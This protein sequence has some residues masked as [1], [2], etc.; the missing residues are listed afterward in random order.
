MPF[1]GFRFCEF[2]FMLSTFYL[3]LLI[4][5]RLSGY[6]RVY[7][8]HRD[9]A[10][11]IGHRTS[12]GADGIAT[13]CLAGFRYSKTSRRHNSTPVLMGTIC[14]NTVKKFWTRNQ[15]QCEIN[16]AVTNGIHISSFARESARFGTVLRWSGFMV[17]ITKL[18]VCWEKRRNFFY[19]RNTLSFLLSP[20]AHRHLHVTFDS[21]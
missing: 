11:D 16:S 8:K 2:R 13:H 15:Y 12:V 14:Y 17:W 9:K 1:S 6:I 3:R 7:I 10:K 4:D 19:K 5:V 20:E 21:A 18:W